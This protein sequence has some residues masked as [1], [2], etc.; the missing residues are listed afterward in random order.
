M[1]GGKNCIN[2]LISAGADPFR[3]FAETVAIPFQILLVGSRHMLRNHAVLPLAPIKT[4]VGCNP[5]M[6]V[7]NLYSFICNPHINFAFYIFIRN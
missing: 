6:I 5:I 7:K 2:Y 1:F 3:P 4:V